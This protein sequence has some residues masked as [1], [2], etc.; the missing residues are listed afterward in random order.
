[1]QARI[2]LS[3]GE[4]ERNELRFRTASMLVMTANRF[5]ADI[6]VKCGKRCVSGKNLVALLALCAGGHDE[7]LTLIADGDD[8]HEALAAIEAMFAPAVA[9]AVEA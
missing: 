7:P 1:M 2:S 8:A 5:H 3:I 6:I 4:H 9:D